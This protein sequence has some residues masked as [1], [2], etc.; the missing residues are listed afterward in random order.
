M[1]EDGSENQILCE[2]SHREHIS[3]FQYIMYNL[4]E[5]QI[6]SKCCLPVFWFETWKKIGKKLNIVLR[7]WRTTCGI[8]K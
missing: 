8:Q 2:I 5:G 4:Q 1:M 3:H 7:D 6:R